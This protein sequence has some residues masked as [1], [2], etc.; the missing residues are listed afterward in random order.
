MSRPLVSITSACYNVGKDVL[1]MVQ[2]I[3]VQSFSD[4][5]LVILDDSSTDDTYATLMSF[6]DDRIKIHRNE[7]N[8]GIPASLNRL[9]E[10]TNGKYIARMDSDDLS[11]VQRIQ[12]Q[13]DFMESN[14]DVDLVG[15]GSIYLD[16]QNNPIG[17]SRIVSTH[18]QICG[19]PSRGINI[20]HPTILAKRTWFERNRYNEKIARTSDFNLLL[21][22]H[23]KS[24]YANIPEYLFYYRL[25]LSF[26]LK[27]EFSSRHYYWKTIA[28]YYLP[29][30]QYC[31]V[32]K[33][34]IMT[35]LKF[36]YECVQ[37]KFRE[38]E[39]AYKHRFVAL[40]DT[41]MSYYRQ[42]ISQILDCE[43]PFSK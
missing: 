3:L 32:G 21:R 41:E 27:K 14:T 38:Q 2:S 13:V 43:I 36:V 4:W 26:N 20:A 8:M 28:D 42:E 37:Y 24:I 40:T 11:A 31:V 10:L 18:E 33:A 29:K 1:G 25:G 6:K 39:D 7:R 9:T 15:T 23:E 35:Y 17:K 12:K 16:S 19:N 34:I 30:K 22:A 5:E